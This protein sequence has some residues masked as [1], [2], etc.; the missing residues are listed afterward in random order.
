M[1]WKKCPQILVG[2]NRLEK[3][4]LSKSKNERKSAYNALRG[5][6]PSL[7]LPTANGAEAIETA[8]RAWETEHPDDLT[9]V[10]GDLTTSFFGFNSQA[11]MAGLF[12]YVLVT[13]DLRASEESVDSKSTVIGRILER[14]VDR[15]AANAA[16]ETLTSE[17]ESRQR[18]IYSEHF[19]DQLTE[20]SEGLNI[21]RYT[22][23]RRSRNSC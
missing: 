23:L 10:S 11:K 20:I 2:M 15:T 12:D 1:A 17:I 8:F 21:C 9:E 14:S 7:N 13:A 18:E 4:V 22:I 6:E 3:Y 19:Q 16:I 5:I